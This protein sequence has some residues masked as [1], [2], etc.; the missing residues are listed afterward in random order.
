MI[1][2]SAP[3]LWSR[4]VSCRIRIAGSGFTATGAQVGAKFRGTNRIGNRRWKTVG[5]VVDADP[6]RRFS[7][8]VTTMGLKV[9]EWSYMFESTAAG[10]KS[11]RTGLTNGPVSSSRSPRWRLGLQT[12]P[13]STELAWSKPSSASSRRQSPPLPRA[14]ANGRGRTSHLSA[15][16]PPR[17]AIQEGA[18]SDGYVYGSSPLS[19][20]ERVSLDGLPI[21]RSRV[22]HTVEWSEVSVVDFTRQAGT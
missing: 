20:T 18:R 3:V 17:M 13:R 9:A 21:S 5:V 22:S 12:A 19:A 8:R 1:V 2:V 14:E 16:D 6:G 7:F 4:D 10:V 15:S 11:P